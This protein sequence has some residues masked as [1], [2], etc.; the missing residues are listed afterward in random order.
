LYAHLLEHVQERH[1][2]GNQLALMVEWLD[3][4]PEVP[5]GKWFKKFPDMIVCRENE[6]V[7]TFL[8]P[9]Q[10]PTGEELP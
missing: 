3:T 6:L 7:K 10:I 4:Q 1:I 5:S 8:T 2:S 9:G